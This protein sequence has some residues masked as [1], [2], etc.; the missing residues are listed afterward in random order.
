[1]PS[2]SQVRSSVRPVRRRFWTRVLVPS[3]LVAAVGASAFA[4]WSAGGAGNGKG[5]TAATVAVTLS[6]GVA[7]PDLRP[8][9]EGNVVLLV[10]NP[11][12]SV[13]QIGSLALDVTQGDEGYAVDAAH[14]ECGLAALAYTTQTNGGAGWAVPAASAGGDGTLAVTLS[15]ALAMSG[16]AANACQG[17]DLTVYLTAGP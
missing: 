16:D 13:A 2:H 11:N 3:V 4:Y 1:M 5:S 12:S 9:G 7:T 10:S 15:D 6:P 17:A 8:G 14:S